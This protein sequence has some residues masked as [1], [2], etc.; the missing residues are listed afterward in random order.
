[1]S[2]NM[3]SLER[4][5]ES[6]EETFYLVQEHQG[7]RLGRKAGYLLAAVGL[8]GT[9]AFASSAVW[10]A[11]GS[12]SVASGVVGFASDADSC[13]VGK[14]NCNVTKCCVTSGMQC[15]EQ[16]AGYAQCRA[17]CTPGPDPTHW[18][19]QAWSCKALGARTAGE[20]PCGD[21]GMDCRKSKCCRQPGMTCYEKNETWSTCK[22]SCIPGGPDFND[23]DGTPWTCKEFGKTKESTAAWVAEECV[24]AWGDCLKV[25][26]CKNAGEQCYKQNDYFGNCKVACTEPGWS[27][28]TFGSRTPSPAP[29]ASG[30][31]PKWAYDVCS[32]L[33]G[34]CTKSHCCIGMDVQCYEKDKTWAQC[35]D[36]CEPGPHADD[37]NETWSCKTLGPRS[38]GV[39]T[40][41]FPSLYCF[42]VLR[43]VGYEVGLI[44]AQ[45][46]KGAGIFGC[47]A[48]SLL[49]ADGSITI[50]AYKSIQFPGA[51]IT[52]SIDHTAGNTE[53]FVHAWDAVIGANVWRNHT[54]TLK[55][56]PDAVLIPDRVRWHLQPHVGNKMYIVNCPIGDMMYGSLEVYSYYG[57]KEWSMRGHDCAAPNNW[58]EDK[59]MTICM[60]F[61]G[62]ARVHDTAIVAD[63]LCLGSDCSNG[64]AAAF[65][66]YKDI[67]QWM[68]CYEKATAPPPKPTIQV[69]VAK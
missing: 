3:N 68:Q 41:G 34:D 15:Y 63:N 43:T 13:T 45:H 39:S 62:V 31:M 21:P 56:D 10:H 59:Y 64:Q 55:V 5:M 18:D 44:K 20:D 29:K 30:A 27:C 8:A 26:C 24:E 16:N 7:R 1:M 51:P 61:L 2:A 25:G 49:T 36:W 48:T 22:P 40:K 46:D 66:P 9:A 4:G 69:Q 6:D 57:I 37:S 35:K 53:L 17:T 14:G 52:V 60:D 28:E 50:G 19:G 38:Y 32:P 47:D 65:H 12:T 42:S 11:G 33:D 54:F 23:V 58:G 67:G